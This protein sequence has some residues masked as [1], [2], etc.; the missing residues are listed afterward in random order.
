MLNN[1]EEVILIG[2]RPGQ[3]ADF[4]PVPLDTERTVIARVKAVKRSEFYEAQNSGY[5]PDITLEL[6]ADE[7]QNEQR[8]RMGDIE[9][10]VIRSYMMNNFRVELVCQQKAGDENGQTAIGG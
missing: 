1:E 7:Y 9:Y 10:T 6:W 8:L 2:V 4:E 3:S 5:H